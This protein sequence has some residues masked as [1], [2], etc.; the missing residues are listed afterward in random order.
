LVKNYHSILPYQPDTSPRNKTEQETLLLNGVKMY[1]KFPNWLVLEGGAERSR[2][3]NTEEKHYD[4]SGPIASA[5]PS[6]SVLFLFLFLF[7][8]FL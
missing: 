5:L 4:V 3:I 8:G 7:G 1:I 6:R 2:I